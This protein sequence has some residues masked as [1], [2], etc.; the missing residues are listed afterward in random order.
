MITAHSHLKPDIVGVLK[1]NGS[2]NGSI[3]QEEYL[4]IF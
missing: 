4:F 2:I 1:A 3:N